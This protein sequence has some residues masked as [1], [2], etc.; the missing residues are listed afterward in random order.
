MHTVTMMHA[1]IYKL[2]FTH[3]TSMSSKCANI[4]QKMLCGALVN[5]MKLTLTFLHTSFVVCT[6]I[7]NLIPVNSIDITSIEHAKFAFKTNMVI[8]FRSFV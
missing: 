2:T 4:Y 7:D 3:H 1:L 6:M 8:N 5:V